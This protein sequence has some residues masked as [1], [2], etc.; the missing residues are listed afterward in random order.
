MDPRLDWCTP[1]QLGPA[2]KHW[3]RLWEASSSLTTCVK[4]GETDSDNIMISETTQLKKH[5]ERPQDY[6]PLELRPLDFQQHNLENG[7]HF[8]TVDGGNKASTYGL[9][10]SRN[11][12][13]LVRNKLVP[14]MKPGKPY[15]QYHSIMW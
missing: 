7:R 11:L 14:W 3:L 1:E 13:V 2:Y 12:N 15:D 4:L 9:N 5:S 8:T 10:H 6:I